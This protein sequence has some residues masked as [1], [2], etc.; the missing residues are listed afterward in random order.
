MPFKKF[1]VQERSS[2]VGFFCCSDFSKFLAV[3]RE[4]FAVLHCA[5]IGDQVVLECAS[6]ELLGTGVLEVKTA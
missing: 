5:N 4:G 2:L 6:P 3:C 1:R